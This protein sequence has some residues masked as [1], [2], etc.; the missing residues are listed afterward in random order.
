LVKIHFGKHKRRTESRSKGEKGFA[1]PFT[2]GS[3]LFYYREELLEQPGIQFFA[4]EIR[5]DPKANGGTAGDFAQGRAKFR[6]GMAES[7]RAYRAPDAFFDFQQAKER[8]RAPS[9]L[10]NPGL[11][12]RNT[13]SL[14]GLGIRHGE[15][16]LVHQ[17]DDLPGK[18]AGKLG[19]KN[20]SVPKLRGIRSNDGSRGFRGGR[21]NETPGEE[22]RANQEG[23]TGFTEGI[24]GIP[25]GKKAVAAKIPINISKEEA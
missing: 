17:R 24:P 5:K 10:G 2:F 22:S 25:P 21:K 16:M 19:D 11:L 12:S 9:L 6:A 1:F 23:L 13:R 20:E 7:P 8:Q 3:R 4:P 15:S 18:S 14:P